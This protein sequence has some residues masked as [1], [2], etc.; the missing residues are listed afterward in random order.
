MTE[1]AVMPR[2]EGY[3]DSGVEWLG[4]IPEHWR[5]AASK[6]GLSIPI[7]D[8]PHIT[9]KLYDDG[10]PFISAESIKDGKISFEHKRGYISE[11]DYLLFSQ[12]YIP[13]CKDVYMVKS[14]ATTGRVAMVK[15]NDRFTIWSPL[16]GSR[17]KT[18]A[19]V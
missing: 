5:V 10:I 3:K 6:R 19:L 12:K 15:T 18:Q 13:R 14:G 4:E 7:T 8:G 11:K 9:P 16:A 2:Y 1:L 17:P